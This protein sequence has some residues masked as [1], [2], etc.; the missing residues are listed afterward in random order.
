MIEPDRK[1]CPRCGHS[2]RG[3]AKIC[4]Q[5]GFAFLRSEA[6]VSQTLDQLLNPESVDAGRSAD[7]AP[8]RK[9]CPNCGHMNRLG[10]KKCS[11]CGTAFGGRV[12]PAREHVQR[13]CPNC[14]ARRRDGAKVCS[15]C[16]YRYKTPTEA[17]VVQTSD[18]GEPIT[19]GGVISAK[20][21]AASA[22][23][24]EPPVVQTGELGEPVTAGET[25][26]AIPPKVSRQPVEPP[27]VQAETLAEP[28]KVRR[29]ITTPKPPDLSGEPAPYLSAEDLKRLR[30][31]GEHRPGFFV[32]LYQ[33]LRDDKP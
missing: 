1:V 24:T 22:A 31:V 15:Y 6:P 21:P 19:S 5:C 23:P 3:T 33:V 18:L 26:T 9:R 28:V 25:I 14:G 2:N 17:P 4:T 11:Q 32:R 20:V 29:V 30:D 10:A 27:V 7:A 12:L 8:L 16:G 13:W